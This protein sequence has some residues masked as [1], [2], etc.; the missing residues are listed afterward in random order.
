MPL[1]ARLK[2]LICLILLASLAGGGMLIAWHA[3][4]R[5]QTELQAALHVGESTVKNALKDLKGAD[6]NAANLRRVVATFDGNRHVRAVLL[7]AL[8]APAASSVLFAPGEHVPGWFVRLIG[9]QANVLRI[10][11]DNGAA[12]LLQTDPVNELEEVWG[13]SRDT[14]LVLTGFALLSALLISAVV[15]RALRSLQGFSTAFARIGAGDYHNPLPV[16]GPPELK[17]LASGLNL[18][19]ER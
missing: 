8:G 17:R 11:A 19:S 6:E 7:G 12:I 2:A 4:T 13:E 1:R 5:V 3:A 16:T 15:G 14:M 9:D 10:P 18:M